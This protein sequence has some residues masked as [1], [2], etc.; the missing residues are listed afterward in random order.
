MENE[1]LYLDEDGFAGYGV[2]K[3]EPVEKCSKMSDILTINNQGVLM[4]RRVQEKFYVGKKLLD[5]RVLRP[6]EDWVF[7]MIYRDGKEGVTYAKRFHIGGFTRDKEYDLTQGT[8]GSRVFFFSVHKTE[9]DS[10]GIAVNVYLKN[11]FKRLRKP[12]TFDFA[13]LRVKGRAVMGNIVTKNPVERIARIM[14]TAAPAETAPE[15]PEAPAPAPQDA[16]QVPP[17]PQET[18]AP[19][20]ADDTP[21]PPMEDTQGTFNFDD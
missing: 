16:P 4:V 9:E 8:K 14:P 18:P 7:N 2:R 17:A 10:A 1:T 5:I 20:P 15:T 21:V 13:E 19:P 3:G 6:G 11:Q 12:V